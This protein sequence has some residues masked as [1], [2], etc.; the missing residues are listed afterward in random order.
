MQPEIS[1]RLFDTYAR[2]VFLREM[3]RGELP[4]HRKRS[5]KW[6]AE[7]NSLLFRECDQLDVEGQRR[8]AEF[9]DDCEGQQHTQGAVESAC[10]RHCVDMRKQQQCRPVGGSSPPRAADIAHVVS[11]RLESC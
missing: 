3:P 7:T 11:V 9:F 2:R 6:K 8:R 10:I 1:Q 5:P 4:G